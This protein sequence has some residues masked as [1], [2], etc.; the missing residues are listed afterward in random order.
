MDSFV[1]EAKKCVHTWHSSPSL[2]ENYLLWQF[3]GCDFVFLWL[4][5]T[6]SAGRLGFS[7]CPL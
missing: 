7:S 6:Y 3:D 4:P 2:S 1:A 5:A